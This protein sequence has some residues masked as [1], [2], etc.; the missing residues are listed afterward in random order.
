MGSGAA[1]TGIR[2]FQK[3][4]KTVDEQGRLSNSPTARICPSRAFE[5]R[6]RLHHTTDHDESSHP[7][8]WGTASTPEEDVQPLSRARV[9]NHNRRLVNKSSPRFSDVDL[10]P[11]K[12]F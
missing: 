12:Y 6:A 3:V 11:E 10:S 4:L 9:N 7:D 2:E 5:L 8:P 1:T